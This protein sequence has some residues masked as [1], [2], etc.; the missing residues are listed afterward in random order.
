MPVFEQK[1]LSYERLFK[2]LKKAKLKYYFWHPLNLL[3]N[4]KRHRKTI[5]KWLTTKIK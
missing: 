5:K 2:Y 1:D 3:K 4:L